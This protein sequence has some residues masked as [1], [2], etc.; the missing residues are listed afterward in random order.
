MVKSH[1]CEIITSK[2]NESIFYFVYVVGRS[3]R[4]CNTRSTRDEGGASPGAPHPVLK[5]SLISMSPYRRRI[6][7]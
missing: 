3:W 4:Y 6:R 1:K 5:I 2:N 7:Y